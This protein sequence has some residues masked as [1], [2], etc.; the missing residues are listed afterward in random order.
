MLLEL[1]E[2]SVS[3]KGKSVLENVSLSLDKDTIY[4]LVGKSGCGK[5]TLL[6]A[7]A[8]FQKLDK[9]VIRLN[10]KEVKGPHED[11]CMVHQ[12]HTNF[13][14]LNCLDNLLMPIEAVKGKVTQ[15]DIRKAKDIL[16]HVDLTDSLLKKPFQLSGGMNQRL[17]I[18]RLIMLDPVLALMDE[19]F[20]ALD[21]K[22]KLTLE[23]YIRT[24]DTQDEKGG[25]ENMVL[26]VTH[27]MEEASRVAVGRII[28]IGA[29]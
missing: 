4:C 25:K 7:I 20:G 15:A 2:V 23:N 8:G 3:F 29:N 16:M 18:A 11:I 1:D 19:P 14:W 27:D 24:F 21:P 6:R 26:L 22:T 10:G 9:G 12:S 5:S 13:A 17:A 28:Q